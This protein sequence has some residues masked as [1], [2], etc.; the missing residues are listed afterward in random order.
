MTVG[1]STDEG[2]TALVA[3]LTQ[4]GAAARPI[5]MGLMEGSVRLPTPAIDIEFVACGMGLKPSDFPK[6]VEK[7]I[8]LVQRGDITFRDKALNAEKA[9]AAAVVIYNNREGGFFGSLGEEAGRPAIPVIS[10]N[11]ADGEMMLSAAKGARLRLTP[12]EV[13]QPDRM[14]EFSSRGPNN[15]LWIKPEIMAPGVNIHSATIVRAAVPGGGM[16]DAT[17]YISASGTSMATPHVAGAVA[18]IRQAN[19]DWTSMQ[20]KAALVNTARWMAGQG[21]V[22]DQ[23]NGAMDLAR[24]IDCQ[25]ILVTAATPFAPT[26]TFGQVVHEGKAVTVSQPLTIL[27]LAAEGSSCDYRLRVELAGNPEG[28]QA[29]LT[30]GS[31]SCSES[32]CMAC[33]DLTLTVD[34]TKVKDGAYYGFVHAEADWG[35]L[36]LPFYCEASQRPMEQPPEHTGPAPGPGVPPKRVGGIPCC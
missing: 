12:E 17:G 15:D 2:V 22:M 4:E 1:A 27:P 24:A 28:I 13:A 31:I 36:R 34:G 29:E 33:F 16:P 21:T 3:E 7:K 9:G 32:E 26:H 10:I 35:T 30:A 18:L 14:A 5:E 25:A 19:S 6:A 23:G 11:K 8:A 20:V